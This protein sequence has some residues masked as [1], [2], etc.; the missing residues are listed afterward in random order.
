MHVSHTASCVLHEH[1][2]LDGA[3]AGDKF[4]GDFLCDMSIS[5]VSSQHMQVDY[6]KVCGV[7]F[8]DTR[9]LAHSHSCVSTLSPPLPPSLPPT[10]SAFL[11]VQVTQQAIKRLLVCW[12]G[13]THAGHWMAWLCYTVASMTNHRIVCCTRHTHRPRP[14]FAVLQTPSPTTLWLP[15][16]RVSQ[17]AIAWTASV[18]F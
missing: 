7:F 1:K 17:A 6:D 11:R 9:P 8:V 5:G 12:K 15:R 14:T 4:F 16:A 13:G 18:S 2:A 3:G 10:L